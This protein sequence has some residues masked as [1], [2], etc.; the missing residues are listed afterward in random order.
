MSMSEGEGI[1][2]DDWLKQRRTELDVTRD[3]LS[4]RLGFSL[5]LLRKLESGESRPSGQIAHLLAD[6]FHIPAE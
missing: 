4:E 1:T 3:E 6:Y 5:D 2:F